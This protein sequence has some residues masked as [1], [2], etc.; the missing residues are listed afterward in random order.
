M[1]MPGLKRYIV[2][3]TGG[4][5]GALVNWGISFVLTSLVGVHYI[6]S[7]LIAQTVNI[8]VNFAW[9]CLIT[10]RV[11]DD[12]AGRF[13]RFCAASVATALASIGLVYAGKEWVVDQWYTVI[14][15][16]IDLNYLAVIIAVTFVIS[17]V[18]FFISKLWIFNRKPANPGLESLA[19]VKPVA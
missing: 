12:S 4:G 17:I 15:R 11:R 19:D 13:A 8:V 7:Y 6:I 5:V 3:A 18:N 14:V 9:H 16:G 1:L 10:F 2:F